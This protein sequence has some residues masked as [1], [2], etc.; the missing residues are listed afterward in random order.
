MS[1]FCS[2]H[3]SFEVERNVKLSKLFKGEKEFA[4]SKKEFDLVLYEHGFF[5]KKPCIV[6]EINGGEHFGAANRERSDRAK[7]EICNKKGIKII[8]IPNSFVKNYE[9][10]MDIIIS[11]KNAEIPIQQTIFDSV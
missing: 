11:A 6:F 4:D 7:M 2:C 3:R 1:H 5:G 8:F 10:I 9:Y